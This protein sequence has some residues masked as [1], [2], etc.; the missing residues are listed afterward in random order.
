[1]TFGFMNAPQTFQ[2]I[3]NQVF[4]D[5]LDDCVVVYI[6]LV[7]VTLVAVHT[8]TEPQLEPFDHLFLKYV[9]CIGSLGL[10]ATI[11][12]ALYEN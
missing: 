12:C 4:F 1:M 10:G 9:H 2:R 11:L 7:Q 3:M 6:E 8:F 5:L